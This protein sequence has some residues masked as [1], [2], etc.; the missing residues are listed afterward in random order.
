MFE[1][2][3]KPRTAAAIQSNAPTVRPESF[4]DAGHALLVDDVDRFSAVLEEFTKSL[5]GH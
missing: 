1:S 2:A 3:L 4:V 5:P